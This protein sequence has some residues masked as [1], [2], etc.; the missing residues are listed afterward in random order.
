[1]L[2]VDAKTNFPMFIISSILALSGLRSQKQ[3]T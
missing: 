1:M 2:I 3:L